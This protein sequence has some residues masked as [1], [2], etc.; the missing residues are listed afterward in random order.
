MANYKKK[1]KKRTSLTSIEEQVDDL[2]LLDRIKREIGP[3]IREMLLKGASA[4]EISKK[5]A[6]YAMARITQI[7]LTDPDSSKALSAAKDLIDRADG[8]AT[9]TK[10]IK[11]EFEEMSD[12]E[13]D[14]IL[15]SSEEDLESL[16]Q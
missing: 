3:E 11:H 13:L 14:A 1:S 2:L 10:K 8:K 6:A 5:Y 9:E 15:K 16:K 7:A 4:K 12:T